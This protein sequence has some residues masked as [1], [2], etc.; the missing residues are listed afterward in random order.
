MAATIHWV[1]FDFWTLQPQSFSSSFLSSSGRMAR[2][3]HFRK[4]M[5]YFWIALCLMLFTVCKVTLMERAIL[6]LLTISIQYQ[7]ISNSCDNQSFIKTDTR[8][9]LVKSCKLCHLKSYFCINFHVQT[10]NSKPGLFYGLVF[11]HW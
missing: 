9:L 1:F 5:S 4:C 2:S 6:L 8:R 10:S 11:F 3:T 7:H